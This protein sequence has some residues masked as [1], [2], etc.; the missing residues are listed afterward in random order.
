MAQEDQTF[1]SQ[2]G[3]L[4]LEAQWVSLFLPPLSQEEPRGGSKDEEL[5]SWIRT[6]I[7]EIWRDGGRQQL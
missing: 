5:S 6:G 4:E 3:W 7:R 1:R 2:R